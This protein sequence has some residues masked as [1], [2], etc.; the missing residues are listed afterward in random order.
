MNTRQWAVLMFDF[1]KKDLANIKPDELREYRKA[2]RSDLGYGEEEITAIE[3]YYD[4]GRLYNNLP[5]PSI[6]DL[7]SGE[8]N[9]GAH[10]KTGRVET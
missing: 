1:E 4:S 2:A 5:A 3:K 6:F 7:F 9:R 10:Q 8:V